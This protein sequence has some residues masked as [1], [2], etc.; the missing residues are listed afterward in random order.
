MSEPIFFTCQKCEEE[1]NG[2]IHLSPQGESWCQRCSLVVENENLKKELRATERDNT[3]LR[4][5]LKGVQ[6][7][8]ATEREGL[9]S[10]LRSRIA[11]QQQLF[12][13]PMSEEV[14]KLAEIEISFIE[15]YIEI[16]ESDKHRNNRPTV[17]VPEA[18]PFKSL[19]TLE[20]EAI[21]SYI[22]QEL[23]LARSP[24]RYGKPGSEEFLEGA[25]N[26]L[27]RLLEGLEKNKHRTD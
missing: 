5:E 11:Q 1:V 13:V 7:K 2:H 8:L 12:K 20:R 19:R 9:L 3:R 15:R 21:E 25:E 27:N 18:E 10:W 26:V 4:A 16:I 6:E 17:S 23:G 14:R 22:R 24:E